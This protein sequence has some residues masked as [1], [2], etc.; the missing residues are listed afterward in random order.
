MNIV[1]YSMIFLGAAL[2]IFNIYGFIRFAIKVRNAGK[3]QNLGRNAILYIPVALLIM[4]F[5]GYVA[6]G[7]FVKPNIIVAAILFGGS[8]FV[9][10]MYVLLERILKRLSKS[11]ELEAKLMATEESN[12]A[13]TAFLSD[14]SHEM[15]TPLNIILGL[16]TMVLKDSDLSVN[17]RERIEK[18]GSSANYLLGIINNILDINSIDTG[19]FITKNEE[20]VLSEAIAQI[21]IIAKLYCKEKNI[22]YL[23]SASA[24]TDGVY[25]GDC[26]RFKQIILSLID[27]AIKYTDSAGTVQLVVVCREEENEK[28]WLC[29]T[30]KDTGAGIDQKL[31]SKIFD[32]APDNDN[33]L[34]GGYGGS[35]LGLPAA[36]KLATKLG[37]TI[38]V[39][40]GK[41][42]GTAFTVVFPVVRVENDESLYEDVSLEGKRILIV[43]DI[44]ENAEIVADLLELEGAESEHAEN[45]QVAVDMF[46]NNEPGYYDVVLMDLRMPVMDGLTAAR[47]IRKTDREDAKTVPIIALTAN[48][49][50]SDVKE[51]LNAGM[52]MHLAKPTD[53][54]KLYAAI[55]KVLYETKAQKEEQL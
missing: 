44:Q 1:I 43:E 41:N 39:K 47:E 38:S 2:M 29:F 40:S 36:K 11:K 35:G 45:G 19:E 25:I 31:L 3:G 24:G 21:D 51:S 46:R 5:L 8:I 32:G 12:R 10:I 4:F 42:V 6:V 23:S 20:F 54:E 30:V 18:I 14:M 55:R 9:F 7:I 34:P 48:A 15:R 17:T 50:E 28:T 53:C 22:T 33:G 27:N 13:K 16:D 49:F 52:N 37:G 26:M